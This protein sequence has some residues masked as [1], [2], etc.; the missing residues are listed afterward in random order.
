MSISL[1]TSSGVI[2][3]DECKVEFINLKMHSMYKYIVFRL[4]DDLNE[5]II[6]KK[7]PIGKW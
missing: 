2:V 7:A 3:N 6:D 5:V 1:Q 4:S